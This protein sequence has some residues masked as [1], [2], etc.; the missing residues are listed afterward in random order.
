MEKRNNFINGVKAGIPIALGYFA[1]SFTFGMMAVAGGLS[2]GDAVLIS[3]TNLTSAG[4]FAGLSIILSNGSY[5]EMML[6][7]LVINLR[8]SLM[9]FSLSQ[10]LTRKEPWFH[11]F[12]I[13]FGVT[14][15]IFAVSVSQSGKTSAFFNYGS[16]AVAI[17]G[18]VIGTLFGALLGNILPSFIVSALS[19]AIYGMFIA[20]II[21]PAKNDRNVLYVVIASMILSTCFTYLP[22]LNK[23]S[24]G[25]V[26]II[27]T[28]IVS[29]LAAK[30]API[31]EEEVNHE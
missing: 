20:I 16:M 29:M 18:W 7:Q 26:I 28:V 2:I 4:Q 10:K 11:R 17:P 1:V 12:I 15:E 5:V 23:V 13:S 19:V 14:D 24:S 9:S 3:T 31:K 8:Y 22:I 30:F 27:C 21:P 25:F 6:T